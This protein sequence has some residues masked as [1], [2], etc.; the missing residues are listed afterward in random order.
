MFDPIGISKKGVM[1]AQNRCIGEYIENIQLFKI[2]E[3]KLLSNFGYV[4]QW[5][6][7]LFSM[8]MHV[9]VHNFQCSK[10]C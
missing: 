1:T 4:Q 7:R 3:S 10:L 6:R 5:K 8:T 2:Y 9:V